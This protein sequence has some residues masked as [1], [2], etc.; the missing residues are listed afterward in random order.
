MK[1]RKFQ[2]SCPVF[3]GFNRY[4]DIEKYNNINDILSYFLNSC[5]E[6]FKTNNLID[7]YEFFK[8]IKNNY[9]IHDVDFNTLINSS[10]NDDIIYVCRHTNCNTNMDNII[11]NRIN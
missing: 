10:N 5:E 11:I 4:I 6:F 3:W 9:H 1:L 8:S 2:I 7:L